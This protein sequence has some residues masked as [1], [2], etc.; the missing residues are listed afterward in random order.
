MTQMTI[1][2]F[3]LSAVLFP[4]GPL[5]LRIFEARYLDMISRC[6]RE[7]SQFGV[8]QIHSGTDVSEVQ[9][10]DIGTLARIAD[11]YQGSDGILG[12]T[13]RGTRKFRLHAISRQPDG[14]YIGEAAMLADE[15][16]LKLPEEF[17]SMAS[18]LETV[19]DDLGRLYDTIDKHYDDAAWVGHRLAEILPMPSA[20]KQAC[21]ELMDPIERLRLLQ[22]MLRPF[23]R[24]RG[25]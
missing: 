24:E 5:P 16:G 21:L 1:P 4:G 7:E 3:P 22:P 15:P 25:Q 18:L 2:L 13:A 10:A 8:L 17:R 12:I 9:T 23:R 19:I 6:L 20:E 14:L 11:W